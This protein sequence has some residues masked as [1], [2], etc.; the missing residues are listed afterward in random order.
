MSLVYYFYPRQS[1]S[2]I[3][4]IS[5]L[6]TTSRIQFQRMSQRS[7]QEFWTEGHWGGTV[8]G[9]EHATCTFTVPRI[10]Q[11]SFTGWL[12]CCWAANGEIDS[13]LQ[14]G[15]RVRRHGYGLISFIPLLWPTG[16]GI[17]KSQDGKPF[18]NGN[19]TIYKCSLEERKSTSR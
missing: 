6:D 2:S 9:S 7:I 18:A 17:V 3:W 1:D 10:L 13:E 16:G 15:C 8:P 11:I 14:I 5:S 4:N 12:D 19:C